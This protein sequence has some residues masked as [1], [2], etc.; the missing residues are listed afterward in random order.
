MI[1][2]PLGQLVGI[3]FKWAGKTTQ[4]CDCLGLANLAREVGGRKPVE[5]F[6]WVYE[7]YK[8]TVHLPERTVQTELIALG[9]RPV[10]SP[11]DLDVLVLRGR[12]SLAIGTVWGE[13]VLWFPSNLSALQLIDN[14]NGVLG[15]YRER[16]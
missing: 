3:P 7:R 13:E 15:C 5:G 1:V 6:W 9:W 8:S 10:T 14:C 16:V 12:F 2:N 4:G 11:R